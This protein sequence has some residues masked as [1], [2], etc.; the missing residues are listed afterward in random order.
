MLQLNSKLVLEETWFKAIDWM[1]K[2]NR[3]ILSLRP[4]KESNSTTR[5]AFPRVRVRRQLVLCG[6][7]ERRKRS[8]SDI[9]HACDHARLTCFSWPRSNDACSPLSCAGCRQRNHGKQG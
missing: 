3:V 2:L 7:R 5:L 1:Y 9:S 4:P 8:T 6:V